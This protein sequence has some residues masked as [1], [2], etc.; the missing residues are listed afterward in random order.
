MENLKLTVE[1]GEGTLTI[2]EGRAPNPKELN[3]VSIKGNIYAVHDYLKQRTPNKDTSHIIVNAQNG[4]IELY[5]DADCNFSKHVKGE[6]AINS[7]LEN[8]GINTE[9]KY[10]VKDLVKLLKFNKHMF[11]SANEVDGVIEKLMR[12]SVKV[13]SQ[14]EKTQPNQSGSVNNNYSKT[15]EAEH[16]K[17]VMWCEVYSGGEKVK[18]TVE[19]WLDSEGQGVLFWLESVTLEELIVSMSEKMVGEV[20]EKIEKLPEMNIPIINI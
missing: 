11:E 4:T 9:K 1:H 3:K 12:L 19:I 5:E 18:F 20:I 17:L 7:K 15:V 13:T 10:T 6:I 16:H 2:L 14:I 8:F